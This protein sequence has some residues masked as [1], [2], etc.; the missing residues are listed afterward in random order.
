METHEY[1]G[2]VTKGPFGTGSKSER[3][4][5]YMRRGHKS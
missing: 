1:T 3:E 5:I 2:M 4:A